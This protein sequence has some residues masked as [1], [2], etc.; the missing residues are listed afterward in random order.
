VYSQII[1]LFE[2]VEY[3]DTDENDIDKVDTFYCVKTIKE[4]SVM[5]SIITR[6]TRKIEN[7]SH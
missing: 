2:I 3:Y 7:N 4:K 5:L 6:K 1:Q